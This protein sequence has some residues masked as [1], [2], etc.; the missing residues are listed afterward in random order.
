MSTWKA[1]LLMAAYRTAVGGLT[2]CVRQAEH[3][4]LC[5]LQRVPMHQSQ[6]QTIPGTHAA[7]DNAEMKTTSLRHSILSHVSQALHVAYLSSTHAGLSASAGPD[8]KSAE[9]LL[10]TKA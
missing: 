5:L 1:V 2:T 4:L 9:A 7:R 3:L 6:L 8:R 10:L